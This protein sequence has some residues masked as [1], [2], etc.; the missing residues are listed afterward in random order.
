MNEQMNVLIEEGDR[1][2]G[3]REEWGMEVYG[4]LG[5]VKGAGDGRNKK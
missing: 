5:I 3:T 1:W 4:R 2:A